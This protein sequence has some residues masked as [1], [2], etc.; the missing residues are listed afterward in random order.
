MSEPE[1][2]EDLREAVVAAGVRLLDDGLTVST[3]GNVS[4]L[5]RKAG[6]WYITPSGMDYRSLVPSDICVLDLS[7]RQ[8]AGGRAPSIE[9]ELHR[10]AYLAR[11]DVCAVVHTH[12]IWSTVF[13]CA[14]QDIP[15]DALDVGAQALGDT[16]RVCPYRLP[17]TRELAEAAADALGERSMACLLRSHGAV[18]VGATLDAAFKVATTLETVAEVLWRVRAMGAAYQPIAPEDVAAMQR[19]VRTSYGQR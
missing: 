17:G 19:F 1:V 7:G 5:D 15:I 11:P 18:C 12:P 8:V 3:W 2:R 13:G 10:L 9:R 6:L 4:V 14:G 16:V